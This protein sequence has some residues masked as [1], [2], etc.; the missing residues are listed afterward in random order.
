MLYLYL[1]SKALFQLQTQRADNIFHLSHSD[2]TTIGKKNT[3]NVSSREMKMGKKRERL[4]KHQ[5]KL[6]S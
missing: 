3:G 2:H 4:K 6:I 5:E 1:Y